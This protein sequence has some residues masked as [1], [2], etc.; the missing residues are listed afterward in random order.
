MILTTLLEPFQFGLWSMRW[1][2]PPLSPCPAR[3]CLYFSSQRLGADGR[4]HEPRGFPG[5]VLAWIRGIPLAIGAFIAGLFC[6]VAT[7]ISTIT[8]AS[9]AI[10]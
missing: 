1:S 2:S 3:C 10:P 7:D 6:A 9:N 4:C 5:I 8:A